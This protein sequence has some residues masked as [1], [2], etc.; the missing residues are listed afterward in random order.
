MWPDRRLLNLLGIDLPI[1]QAPMAGANDAAMAIAASVA[2]GLGSLPCAML[3]PDGIEREVAR[4]RAATN[5]PFNVNFFCHEPPTADPARE[6]AWRTRL[7]PFYAE[8][9][10]DPESIGPAPA[11]APFDAR[12]CGLIEALRPPVA[13]FHFGL[14]EAALLE[15]VKKAGCTVLSSA[16]TVAEAR[17]LETRGCDAIIAQG[18]EAGG[19]RGMFLEDRV[20]SQVGV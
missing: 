13:S 10:L 11:R 7:A 9:G 5:R 2:G 12:L 19:H 17:W 4:L 8:Y 14:P 15:R 16:T 1:I 20:T 6:A 3:D 18:V